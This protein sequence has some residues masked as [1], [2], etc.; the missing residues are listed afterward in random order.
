MEK[1]QKDFWR[2]LPRDIKLRIILSIY[3]IW[4]GSSQKTISRY[5]PFVKKAGGNKKTKAI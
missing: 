1:K 2:I 4:D 3:I 5:F